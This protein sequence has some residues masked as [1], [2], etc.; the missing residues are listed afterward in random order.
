SV[1]NVKGVSHGYDAENGRFSGAQVQVTSKA[2]TNQFHGSLFLTAHRP[3]LNAYQRFNGEGNSVLRD[4]NFFNQLGGSV[5]GP[6]WKN[7][8]FAFF[9]YETVREP[10]H[11]STDNG[12]YETSA[13]DSL[14]TAASAGPIAQTYLSF[15]GG[16]P[17]G[18][19][20]NNSATCETAG[21][22]VNVN[23][24]NVAGGLDIGSPLT[25]GFGNQDLGW[26]DPQHPGVGGGLDGIP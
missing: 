15:P 21:F 16:T 8:I 7:K 26:A 25:T 14:A 9:A 22:I 11:A 1:E 6:I 19:V 10:Q 24:A 13:F 2:G 5:G 20:I 12:W 18:G 17:I 3:G 4:N 23:C